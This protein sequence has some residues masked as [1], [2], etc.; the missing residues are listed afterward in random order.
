[1]TRIG[2]AQHVL[3]QAVVDGALGGL[4]GTVDGA[5]GVSELA[6]RR[7]HIDHMPTAADDHSGN[8]RARHVEQALDV[9]VDHLFPVL[10]VAE[11]ELVEA[12]AEARIVDEDVDFGPLRRQAVN[13]VL[14]GAVIAD[15]EIDGVDGGRSPFQG[16][17]RHFGEF[18]GPA[19]CQQEARSFGG[20]GKSSSRANAGAGSGDKDDLPVK[21]HGIIL[22]N[23]AGAVE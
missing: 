12:A 5:I 16:R 8:D 22:I 9:G 4:A 21:T 2:R 18:P 6:G 23:A 20:K 13:R 3:A 14:H 17:G 15:V 11:V 7:P 10:D 1:M 19:R